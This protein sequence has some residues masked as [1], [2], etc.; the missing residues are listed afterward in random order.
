MDYTRKYIRVNILD[1]NDT[2]VTK[3]NINFIILDI[4]NSIPQTISNIEYGM[5]HR[6]HID[7]DTIY[8]YKYDNILYMCFMILS[9]VEVDNEEYLEYLLSN[10]DQ[11][12][13]NYP[14]EDL[15]SL[16]MNINNI[17][18]FERSLNFLLLRKDNYNNFLERAVLTDKI[19]NSRYIVIPIHRYASSYFKRY[20]S[21][22]RIGNIKYDIFKEVL[23]RYYNLQNKYINMIEGYIEDNGIHDLY[24]KKE[25][26]IL[27]VKYIEDNRYVVMYIL[28]EST[29]GKSLLL[30]NDIQRYIQRHI[31]G[32]LF[33]S[34]FYDKE[35]YSEILLNQDSNVVFQ[36]LIDNL[37]VETF[38]VALSKDPLHYSENGDDRMEEVE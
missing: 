12:I 23:E 7:R 2:I 29:G 38:P 17:R 26:T 33:P 6:L 3:E 32:I 21:D 8:V 24:V 14:P 25:E 27:S 4:Y 31:N 18:E 30:Y 15:I 20:N 5:D 35:I 34:E 9:N 1:L 16:S 37:D 19:S 13:I 10:L 28:L 36:W 11:D 22:L